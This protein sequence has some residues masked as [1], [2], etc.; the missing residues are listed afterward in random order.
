MEFPIETTDPI[1]VDLL[2]NECANPA[3]GRNE[4]DGFS[5]YRVETH[6]VAHTYTAKAI[7]R[8]PEGLPTKYLVMCVEYER[9]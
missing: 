6:C 9:C 3:W 2:N 1:L 5:T 7:E 8:D 4:E